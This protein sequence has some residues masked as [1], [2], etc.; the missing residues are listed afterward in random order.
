MTARSLRK[1][2]N[3]YDT[4]CGEKAGVSKATVSRVLNGKNVVRE[5]MRR[6]YAAARVSL[7]RGNR[8]QSKPA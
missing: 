2:K 3:G 4:G 7:H 6:R 8:I 5:D 1:G